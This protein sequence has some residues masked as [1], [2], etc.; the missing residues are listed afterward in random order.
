M[1]IFEVR[2]S[3]FEFL[4]RRSRANEALCFATDSFFGARAF[5]DY[6]PVFLPDAAGGQ[7]RGDG[8]VCGRGGGRLPGGHR[9][10]AGEAR[11]GQALS[12]PV[13]F[14]A[15]RHGDGRYGQKLRVRAGRARHLFV[16]ASGDFAVG[17]DERAADGR[18][19]RPARRGVRRGAPKGG[20]GAGGRSARFVLPAGF[21][22]APR[23][24][25]RQFPA[26]FFRGAAPDAL[27]RHPARLAARDRR[28]RDAERRD[29]ADADADGRHVGEVSA[30]GA[31]GGAGRAFQGLCARREGTGRGGAHDSRQKCA[32][33]VAD[34]ACDAS[35][36]FRRLA[37]RR[38]R[39]CRNDFY[40]GRRGKIGSGRNH[41][42][43][44]PADSGVRRLDG[45]DLYGCQFRGRSPV[46]GAG[47]ACAMGGEPK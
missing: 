28:R 5:R 41:D 32:A 36:A 33:L 30:A 10:G 7:R 22:R 20:G 34:D 24:L 17:G 45:G 6:V 14:L 42:A 26:E 16:E 18:G 43:G 2:I 27:F 46:L 39:H 37:A 15:G 29:P 31:G 3:Y 25:R 47:P 13:C 40:V 38:H 35:R 23:Q 19:V 8:D 12:R 4:E 44:L 21:C 1:K 11:T 9:R